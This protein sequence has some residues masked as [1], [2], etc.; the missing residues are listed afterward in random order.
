[1]LLSSRNK[2]WQPSLT[3]TAAV[4]R[5]LHPKAPMPIPHGG[6]EKD[7]RWARLAFRMSVEMHRRSV[8]D[9]NICIARDV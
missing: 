4:Q 9:P 6:R 2:C 5:E 8:V 7:L 1:M 3:L